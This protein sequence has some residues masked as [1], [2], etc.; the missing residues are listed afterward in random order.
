MTTLPTPAA[1]AVASPARAQ[2]AQALNVAGGLGLS[3]VPCYTVLLL[4]T[5]YVLRPPRNAYVPAC[6]AATGQC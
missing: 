5:L 2:F 3:L 6:T 4:A 1:T